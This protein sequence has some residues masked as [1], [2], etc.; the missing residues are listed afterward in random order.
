M[1]ENNRRAQ[2]NAHL[3]QQVGPGALEAKRHHP[4]QRLLR[5]RGNVRVCHHAEKDKSTAVAG[6]KF[7]EAAVALE[8]VEQPR[9]EG[10]LVIWGET[11]QAQK[12]V[13]EDKCGQ[14]CLGSCQTIFDAGTT[15]LAP[16]A[17]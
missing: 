14:Q 17:T 11:G 16:G 3:G 4:A 7:V 13:K 8:A 6:R 12:D 9:G 1:W 5:P 15:N 2:C 10:E